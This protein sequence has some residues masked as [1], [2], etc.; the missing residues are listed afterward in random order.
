[1][2]LPVPSLAN[3]RNWLPRA[4]APV[5][6]AV[7]LV[8]G[9]LVGRS[10]LTAHDA[11]LHLAATLEAQEKLVAQ[12][13]QRQRERD[14]SL[15][16]TL[17]AIAQAKRRVNTPAKSAAAIPEVLPSLPEPLKIELPQPT[18]SQPEPPASVTVPQADLKP[19][20]DYAQDCRACG[21]SL[22]AAHDD[23]ADERAKL[24][25]ITVERD[26]AM[27]AVRGG[28][29]WSRLRRNAKWFALGA[30]AGALATTASR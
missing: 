21:A 15:T 10:W 3:L 22:A 28:G 14:N 1:M 17:T 20:Y 30:A 27:R 23:L 13:N 4:A 5:A 19:L 29:F 18:P 6:L 2:N 16:K 26:A 24:T 11:A 12:A 8:V 9:A 7:L 25:A